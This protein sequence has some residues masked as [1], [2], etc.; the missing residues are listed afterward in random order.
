MIT[1]IYQEIDGRFLGCQAL[2]VDAYTDNAIPAPFRISCW[3]SNLFLIPY[4]VGQ[5]QS[6]TAGSW[7]CSRDNFAAF[8]YVY[9]RSPEIKYQ[10]ACSGVLTAL[11]VEY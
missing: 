9:R 1:K 6:S 8:P 11:T 4:M 3:K 7:Q 2:C 5:N 10:D